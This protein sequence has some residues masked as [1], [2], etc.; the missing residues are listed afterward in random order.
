MY[1]WEKLDDLKY[2]VFWKRS[3]KHMP[4][5]IHMR[6]RNLNIWAWFTSMPLK[7]QTSHILYICWNLAEQELWAFYC[8]Q[9]PR[10]LDYAVV[11]LHVKDWIFMCSWMF[12]WKHKTHSS[13]VGRACLSYF[14]GFEDLSLDHF[15]TSEV[16]ILSHLRPADFTWR[17]GC[18]AL[19]RCGF[20]RSKDPSHSRKSSQFWDPN[21]PRREG[22]F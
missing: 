2:V 4:E 6:E 18:S 12:V 13:S 16:K 11:P 5:H 17:F 3:F 20:C 9:S 15:N 1:V 19:L 14:S 22:G 10:V 7:V 8:C 21:F